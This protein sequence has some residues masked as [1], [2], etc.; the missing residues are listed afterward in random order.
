MENYEELLHKLE[1]FERMKLKELPKELEEF[2]TIVAKNGDPVYPWSKVRHV[3]RAKIIS[4]LTQFFESSPSSETSQFSYESMKSKILERFDTFRSAPFTIQRLSELLINPRKEYNRIDKYMRALEKNLLVVSVA[5]PGCSKHVHLNGSVDS[6]EEG[7]QVSSTSVYE[8]YRQRVAGL[9]E[10]EV[11]AAS[12]CEERQG[13]IQKNGQC[14][15]VDEDVREEGGGKKGDDHAAAIG[16]DGDNGAQARLGSNQGLLDHQEFHRLEFSLAESDTLAIVEIVSEVDC[17]TAEISEDSDKNYPLSHPMM[18]SSSEVHET[19]V[20]PVISD[21]DSCDTV[22]E[23][24]ATD[25]GGSVPMDE[26]LASEKVN[27]LD[28]DVDEKEPFDSPPKAASPINTLESSP[29][30]DSQKINAVDETGDAKLKVECDS[31]GLSDSTKV[32]VISS[33]EEPEFSESINGNPMCSEEET[34]KDKEEL[35]YLAKDKNESV[36]E[37]PCVGV[38]GND[39][40]NVDQAE[41]GSPGKSPVE[42]NETEEEPSVE[43]TSPVNAN[44]VESE[45]Y[46]EELISTEKKDGES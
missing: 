28:K 20:G 38:E 16:G 43:R 40:V 32:L 4:V 42:S 11:A 6:M 35:S 26:D 13:E 36:T 45:N 41:E 3:Y 9:M 29:K 37:E 8:D 30:V 19:V 17:P 2:L 46:N 23:V 25:T 27:L 7:F 44:E 18:E 34:E 15:R 21:V 39:T 10:H 12:I 24:V 31:V 1:E 14:K 22:T 33:P 5:E